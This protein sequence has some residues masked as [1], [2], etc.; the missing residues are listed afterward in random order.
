MQLTIAIN[1]ISTK[2][3]DEKHVMYQKIYNIEILIYD[4][5]DKVI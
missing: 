5:A 1:F 3:T 4:K 2:D